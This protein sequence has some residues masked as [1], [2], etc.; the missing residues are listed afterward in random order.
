MR[1]RM[2]NKKGLSAIVATL[3]IILLVLVAVGILWTVLRNV[4][5]GGADTIELNQKCGDIQIQEGSISQVG[6]TSGIYSVTFTRKAGGGD[7]GGI[8]LNFFN[9]AGSNSGVVEFNKVIEVLGTETNSTVFSWAG[10]TNL[11][12]ATR[13]DYTVYLLDET[14]NE[15][16]C[17]NT[18]TVTL[19]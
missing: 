15:Q 17:S 2:N 14:G 8:K 4:I 13:M 1:W 18:E 10:G 5:Q 6:A 11:T 19:G 9:A 12:D 16:I 3:I 7:I